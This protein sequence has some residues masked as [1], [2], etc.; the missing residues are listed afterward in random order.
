MG[1]KNVGS[2]AESIGKV[3]LRKL[4]KCAIQSEFECLL[5]TEPVGFSECQF[6]LK[7][8]PST[9]PEEW[10]RPVR[11]QFRTKVLWRSKVSAN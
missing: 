2:S 9:A 5:G 6:G 8:G 10:Q 3:G 1:R 4:R 7:V 11:N